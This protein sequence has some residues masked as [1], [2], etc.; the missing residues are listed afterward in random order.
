MTTREQLAAMLNGREY[1]D[2]IDTPI[3]VLAEDNGLV[4]VYGASDDLMEFGGAWRDEYGGTVHVTE[5][6]VLENECGDDDCPYFL[7]AMEKHKKITPI[8][9]A[10]E[11]SPAWTY[12]TDIPHAT[13]D[14]MEDGEVFCRGI[15]FSVEDIK[16]DN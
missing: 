8:W 10:N 14:I 9:C 13:F 16:N 2:E 15:V 1:G 3:R 12:E 4:I 11:N 5:K 7:K 6:G